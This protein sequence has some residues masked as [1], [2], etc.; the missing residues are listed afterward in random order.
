[1]KVHLVNI[2]DANSNS[3][4][5][6]DFKQVLHCQNPRYMSA[7]GETVRG[8]FNRLIVH[9]ES[10]VVSYPLELLA[11][12]ALEQTESELLDASKEDVSNSE[13]NISFCKCIQIGGR[14]LGKFLVPRLRATSWCWNLKISVIY[15]SKRR[16]GTSL[17]L[18]IMEAIDQAEIK[19][20]G[21]KGSIPSFR[22]LGEVECHLSVLISWSDLYYEA[23]IHPTRCLW[24]HCYDQK[25]C[26][27]Y[28]GWDCDRR[29][30]Q[31]GLTCHIF[32][33]SHQAFIQPRKVCSNHHTWFS[34]CHVQY[35]NVLAQRPTKR[36]E[37][38]RPGTCRC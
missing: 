21:N 18:Q 29:S 32:N 26:N 35:T 14:A 17:T 20:M 36:S 2:F 13:S 10:A 23:R 24:C 12:R 7:M 6:S 1:M 31:V 27:M 5:L 4:I 25:Y 8:I 19:S 16:L 3:I 22:P 38:T 33:D 37:T 9:T 30:D 11:Q 15:A 28:T 34:G